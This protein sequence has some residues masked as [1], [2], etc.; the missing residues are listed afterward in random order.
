VR[1]V[2]RAPTGSPAP[3]P[4]A[5]NLRPKVG[6]VPSYNTSLVALLNHYGAIP[7]ACR[8]YRVKTKGKV[9]RP[10]CYV[11]QDFFLSRRFRNI[12][13]LNAQFCG[14]R[15]GIANL[16]VRA[17]TGRVVAEHRGHRRADRPLAL[18]R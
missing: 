10:Y 6:E 7:R 3:D 17:T 9:E 11:R 12:D 4:Y 5:T 2:S 8:L 14:W 18:V 15:T 16:R 1:H 13:D